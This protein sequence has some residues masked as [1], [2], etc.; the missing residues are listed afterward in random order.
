MKKNEIATTLVVVLGIVFFL[1][2]E[3][4]AHL[5]RVVTGIFV[6]ETRVMVEVVFQIVTAIIGIRG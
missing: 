4:L 6:P 3:F 5:F 2:P 1:H